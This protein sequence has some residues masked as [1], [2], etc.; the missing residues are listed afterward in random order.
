MATVGASSA[1]ARHIDSTARSGRIVIALRSAPTPSAMPE[2]AQ[3]PHAIDVA[4]SP[5]D[6]RSRAM[7]SSAAFAAA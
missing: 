2:P 7:A 5:A 3:A 1:T 4:G 6:R